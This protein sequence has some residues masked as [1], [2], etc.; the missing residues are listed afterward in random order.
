MTVYISKT[1]ENKISHLVPR[2][3]LVIQLTKLLFH[4]FFTASAV[5]IFNVIQLCKLPIP[6]NFTIHSYCE[7]HCKYPDS[8]KSTFDKTRF[9]NQKTKRMAATIF[10]YLLHWFVVD[11][12]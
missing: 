9:D 8:F 6:K 12:I 2:M 4:S 7:Y 10:F 11:I 3:R 5:N 1:E